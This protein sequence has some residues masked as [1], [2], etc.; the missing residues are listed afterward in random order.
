MNFYTTKKVSELTGVPVRTLQFWAKEGIV[1]PAVYSG[2]RGQPMKWA[3]KEVRELII[4]AELR[5]VLSM[6]KLREAMIHLRALGHNPL[7]SG[8]FAIITTKNQNLKNLVKICDHG[9]AIEIMDKNQ[10]QLL[11][12]LL[13]EEH[14]LEIIKDDIASP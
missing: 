11:L 4:L 13:S 1:A 14:E 7:S 2:S 8:R 3:K 10:G 9:E 12:P 6:Q 5:K